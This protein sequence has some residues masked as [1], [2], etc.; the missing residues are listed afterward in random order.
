MIHDEDIEKMVQVEDLYQAADVLGFI[1]YGGRGDARWQ[2]FRQA[3]FDGIEADQTGRW[4]PA[5]G[6]V[7]HAVGWT[8]GAVWSQKKS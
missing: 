1:L 4:Y 7:P 8:L 5:E 2:S 6:L 3:F